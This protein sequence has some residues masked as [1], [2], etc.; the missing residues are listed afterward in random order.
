MFK[1]LNR[2]EIFALSEEVKQQ[3]LGSKLLHFTE[4][5]TRHYL[6]TFEKGDL[7]LCLQEPFL[8][9]HLA[10][11][12]VESRDSPFAKK[13]EIV[14]HLGTLTGVE[15]LNA[16]RILQLK[17]FKGN[18]DYFL[19]SEFFP[20]KP[21]L[22]LL[23]AEKWI[24]GSLNPVAQTQYI[25]P[26]N[27]QSASIQ[28]DSSINS[29]EIQS[30][31]GLLE[32]E[33]LLK[34]EKQELDSFFK[35]Q[36][37][38]ANKGL[39]KAEDDLHKC[40]EWKSI[41]HEALLLQSNLFRLKKGMSELLVSDWEDGG[42][43][44]RIVLDPLKEPKEELEKRFK[45]A[46]KLKNG[47]EHAEKR[48]QGARKEVELWESRYVSFIEAAAHNAHEPFLSFLEK[49]AIQVAVQERKAL[50][51]H[52]FHTAAG[53]KIW[54]GKS[55]ANN[56]KL[57]FS[58]AKGSD[59]WFHVSGY[60][61]SHVVLKV[62]KNKEPDLESVQDAIQLAIA[63]SK[64]KDKGE[65]EVCVTQCKYISRMGKGKT[66]KVQ[67]SKHRNVQACL[68]SNRIKAIKQDRQDQR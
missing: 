34:K 22:Y 27:I 24:L 66:G 7:L 6:L 53:L 64:G 68:D 55:A 45:Q 40:Q 49:P 8:R 50:P 5:D 42:N 30:R 57:T 26:N 28:M 56:E 51:Y 61:G 58:L 32:K 33:H 11:S 35:K 20:K 4:F 1:G 39:K 52:E 48:L 63:Y 44:R 13:I 15:V 60:P 31:Y 46:R 47:L 43:E 41:Q 16:D 2:E 21:N 65:V 38:R 25:P 10:T 12:A 17:F 23:D 62:E 19:I 54:V 67:V 3:L 59:W 9:F 18:Q 14:L 37:S 29:A 36:M